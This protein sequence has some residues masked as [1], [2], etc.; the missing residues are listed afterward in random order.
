MVIFTKEI[1]T[2]II[3]KDSVFKDSQKEMFMKESGCLTNNMAKV[4]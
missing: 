1:G 4:F 2:K 3:D